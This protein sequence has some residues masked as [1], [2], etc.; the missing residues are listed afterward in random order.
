MLKTLNELIKGLHFF[1]IPS[2]LFYRSHVVPSLDE[3]ELWPRE[4]IS[5]EKFPSPVSLAFPLQPFTPYLFIIRL[6]SVGGGM[7]NKTPMP[8][9]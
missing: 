3:M 2:I 6:V 1:S 8:L 5:K 7:H 9:I 4:T